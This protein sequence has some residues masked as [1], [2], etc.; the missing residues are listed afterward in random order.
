MRVVTVVVNWNGGEENLTCIDSLLEQG[1]A[2]EDVVFVD[3]GSVRGS[4][5][6]VRERYPDLTY[7]LNED[8]TGFAKGSNQGIEIALERMVDLVFLVNND[9]EV[10]PGTLA[11]LVR[12]LEEDESLGA[13]GPRILYQ[14]D[15][16]L[17]WCAGGS[18]DYHQ[19]LTTLHGHRKRDDAHWQRRQLVDFLPGCTLLVRR[20]VIEEVGMFDEAFFAYHEDADFC[21]RIHEA[22]YGVACIG[23]ERAFHAPHSTTGGGYNARRKYMMAV[24]SVWFLRK[25]GTPWRWLRMFLFD[26]CSLPFLLVLAPLRGRPIPAVTAKARGILDGLRGV[27]VTARVVDS[28]R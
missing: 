6:E 20:E 17:I 1:I 4:F 13:V 5:A 3:N 7:V 24:N 2:A 10:P 25:H 14:D 21:L 22:G 11:A 28:F 26:V 16:E 27:R 9:V 8:N 18:I 23:E 12:A 15:R 19:N